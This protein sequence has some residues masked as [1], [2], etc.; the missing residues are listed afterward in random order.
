MLR[1]YRSIVTT[2][3][4]LAIVGAALW[5][6]IAD[7]SSVDSAYSHAAADA[8]VEYERNAQADIKESCFSPSGLR[9]VDCAAKARE[10]AREG[11]RKEQDLAAQ[12]ITAWWTKVMGIAALIGMALSAVGVWFVK[13]TLDATLEAVKDTGKATNAMLEANRLAHPPDILVNNIAIWETDDPEFRP[14]ILKPGMEITARVWVVN[15]GRDTAEIKA[16][17][18][19]SKCQI[20]F[21][22]TKLPMIRPYD[23]GPAKMRL[24]LQKLVSGQSTEWKLSASVPKDFSSR[25]Q[26]YVLGL[27]NYFDEGFKRRRITMFCRRYDQRA[28]H[29]VPVEGRPDYEG[30]E[31]KD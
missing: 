9:K 25:Q 27:I 19:E 15:A 11:Q 3:A 2:L 23:I 26:L 6:L 13:R 12:N 29:F 24:G 21:G 4:G 20:Y 7:L 1:G 18:G 16:D 22:T 30:K 10:A 17:E 5:A 8:S 14:P 31:P 28:G